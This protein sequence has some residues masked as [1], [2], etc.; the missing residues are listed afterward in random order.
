MLFHEFEESCDISSAWFLWCITNR[1]LVLYQCFEIK[2]IVICKSNSYVVKY[3]TNSIFDF[4][5]LLVLQKVLE[6]EYA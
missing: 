4:A 1:T 5:L 3:D 2:Y 6:L